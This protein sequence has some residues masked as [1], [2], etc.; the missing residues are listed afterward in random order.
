M[1]L[2][3]SLIKRQARDLIKGNVFKLFLITFIVSLCV[4]LVSGVISGISGYRN[5]LRW[6]SFINDFT[7]GGDFGGNFED[8]F[9]NYL[10]DNFGEEYGEYFD[11][12]FDDYFGDYFGGNT[13]D[14]DSDHFNGFGDDGWDFNNFGFEGKLPLIPAKSDA[15]PAA[16]FN[17]GFGSFSLPFIITLLLAPLSVTLAGL[18][19]SFI[20]GKKF[21]FDE[22]IKTVFTDAFKVNYLKKV[23]VNFLI[24]LITGLLSMLFIIP[25]IIF[26]YSAYFAFQVMCDYPQLSAWEAIKLSKKMIKGNRFEL[27]VMNLSFIP[28]MLLC[29]FVFF[30]PIIYVMPYIQATNALYYENFRIRAIQ[31]GRVTEDDFLSD[32]QRCVK[33][34]TMG[35][36]QYYSPTSA[37]EGSYYHTPQQ[38]QQQYYAAPDNAAQYAPGAAPQQPVSTDIPTPFAE[39]VVPQEPTEPIAPAEP[40][41][42]TNDSPKPAEPTDYPWEG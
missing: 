38:P 31:Q 42:E 18:Y 15:T 30:F 33:Y 25:G 4:S 19:V 6:S 9:E 8:Y 20:R 5:A 23:G 14:D 3:R 29:V 36:N 32:A 21:E 1:N 2:N 24:G 37:Q 13:G 26:S 11:E 27:F 16:V 35:N 34:G 22:G 12:Y 28:W 17:F 41:E 10:K 39:P 40:Q 7:N